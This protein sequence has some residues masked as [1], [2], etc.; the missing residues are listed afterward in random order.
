MNH[1]PSDTVLIFSRYTQL[2]LLRL[3]TNTA[4]MRSQAATLTQAWAIFDGW[5]SDPRVEFYPE[6]RNV[7]SAFRIATKPFASKAASKWVGDCWL[8]SFASA[9]GATLVTFDR[10]LHEF[11]G[12]QGVPAVIPA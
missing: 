1:L 12:K 7:D 6:P 11:A 9:A 4:I 5:M 10:A 3:V 2:G 8:L